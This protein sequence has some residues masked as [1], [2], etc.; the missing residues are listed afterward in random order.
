MA[1]RPRIVHRS[2]K[3]KG[4]DKDQ[5]VV[6][7][8]FAHS[9]A[10]RIIAIISIL[11]VAGWIFI[12]FF[13]PPLAYKLAQ[14]PAGPID[15]PE[16]L[17]QLA[18]LTDSR[19]T[20]NNRIEPLE[21]GDR[22]YP[23]ELDAMRHAQHN[24]NLDAYIFNHGDINDRVVDVLTERA[25]AGVKITLALDAVG[26]ATTPKLY[27]RELR[28]VGGR[29][30]WYHPIRW[31]TWIR[32]NNRTHREILVVDG[33]T[34][35]VG[36][37]GYADWWAKSTKKDPQWRDTMFRVQGDAVAGLQSSFAQNWLES[38]GEI[39][40]GTEY[41]PP[42]AVTGDIPALV[43][44]STPTPAGATRARILFQTLLAAA[45]K[46]IC[47]TTPYFIPDKSAIKE[48]VRAMTERH[49]EVRILLPSEHTDHKVTRASSRALYRDLLKAGARIYEYQPAMIHAK[50]LIIDGVWVVVGSTNFDPRSFGIN[51]E[52]NLA[53]L[54]PA[55]AA[56]L[57]ADFDHDISQ[58]R[59]ITYD[60]WLH[61]GIF[62]RAMG[63]VG[64]FLQRQQ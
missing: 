11:A 46:S 8:E 50:I 60:Q 24:I 26:S 38:S 13:S 7:Q 30:E 36:G 15:S 41:F 4:K 35:F 12:A 17:R 53:A 64:W 14:P 49:V 37:A 61:R 57:T 43:V 21:N 33:Q 51:D 5:G 34:A 31:N 6:A 62:D 47:I 2:T 55:L 59:Q 29:I 63:V 9:K 27:F 1:T 20:R 25:R 10:L 44:S 32:S 52:V 22:F 16:F 40:N 42:P 19:I 3:P 54:D 58:S 18:A 39:L 23:A 48:M 45:K 28:G 56:R